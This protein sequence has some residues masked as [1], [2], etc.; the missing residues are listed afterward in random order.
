M[1]E[2]Q[3]GG[4]S[5]ALLAHGERALDDID[6]QLSLLEAERSLQ[7]SFTASRWR[8]R[9]RAAFCAGVRALWKAG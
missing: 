4:A 8:R 2:G 6:S 3:Q 1:A 9:V 5:P 7:P